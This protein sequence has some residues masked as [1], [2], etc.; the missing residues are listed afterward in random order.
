MPPHRSRAGNKNIP[1]YSGRA[2][3]TRR[4]RP[5][6]RRIIVSRDLERIFKMRDLT[7]MSGKYH[8]KHIRIGAHG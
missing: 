4:T 1:P 3:K 2:G 6:L 5:V 7:T 8:G